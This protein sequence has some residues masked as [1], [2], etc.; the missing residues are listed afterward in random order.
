MEPISPREVSAVQWLERSTGMRE[1]IG[2][3][4]IEHSC[5]FSF[6]FEK[7]IDISLSDQDFLP[8]FIVKSSLDV[9]YSGIRF[10]IV[11]I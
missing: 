9:A 8:Y 1:V 5:Q 11:K 2:S 7:L 6:A 4:L 10:S 3:N